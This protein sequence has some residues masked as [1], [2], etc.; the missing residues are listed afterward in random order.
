M[1]PRGEVGLIFAGIGSTMKIRNAEGVTVPV[2][3]SSTFG[4]VVIMVIVTTLVTP[5][6][7]KWAMGRKKAETT[8]KTKTRGKAAEIQ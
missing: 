4:A 3:D 2:I 7:L 5:P 8:A 1:V 6:A